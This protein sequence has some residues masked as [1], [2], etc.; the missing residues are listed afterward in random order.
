[1]EINNSA[2]EYFLTI[3]IQLVTWLSFPLMVL[4]CKGI[5]IGEASLSIILAAPI[6]GFLFGIIIGWIYGKIKNRQ[7]GTIMKKNIMIP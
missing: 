7:H 1:M 4:L 3:W 5:C 6:T 2:I